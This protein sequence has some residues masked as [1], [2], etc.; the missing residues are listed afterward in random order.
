MRRYAKRD[1]PVADARRYLEPG[2]VV[3][4]SSAW[5]DQRN[6]MTLG[7]HMVLDFTPSLVGTLV[8]SGNHSFNLLRRSRAC[9]INL[10]TAELLDTVVGIGNC[11]GAQVD[12]FE[13]FALE[14]R[15]A[16]TVDAPLLVQCP[17][18]FECRL[19]DASQVRRRGLFIWEIVKAHVAPVPKHPRT[20]HYRGDG[21]FMLAGANVSRRGLF[22]PGML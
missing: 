8:S 18:S 12:K 1:Y 3:L 11:S 22:K 6:V 20:L 15:A 16:T 17:A 19:H 10:P 5:K 2:P 14:T 7:W 13:R 9:V 4:L 21:Q